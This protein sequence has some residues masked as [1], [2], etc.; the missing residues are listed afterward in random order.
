M[1]NHCQQCNIWLIDDWKFCGLLII[2]SF[3]Y[4]KFD[5]NGNNQWLINDLPIDY[6]NHWVQSSILVMSGSLDNA[7]ILYYVK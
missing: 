1:S 6:G 2:H 7:N 5:H 3:D 4:P